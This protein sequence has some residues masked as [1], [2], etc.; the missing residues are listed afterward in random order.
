MPPSILPLPKE[1]QQVADSGSRCDNIGL[2]LD[3]FL[4]V[5]P[6]KNWGITQD[7]KHRQH[8]MQLTRQP[9]WQSRVREQLNALQNRYEAMLNWYERRGS[10]VK[11]IQAQPVW[12]FV[13]GLG[14]AHVLETGITLHRLF[15]L[16]IIPGSA[17]KGAARTWALFKL[18]EELGVPILSPSEA[19]A[20]PP[21][22]LDKFETVI[23][24]QGN[25]E[26]QA[27]LL[28]Q[29]LQDDAIPDGA[30]IR[31]LSLQELR[32][33]W[34]PFFEVFGSTEQAGSIIFLDA[35][36]LEPPEFQLDIMNPHY[37]NYYRTQGPPA[38]WESPN[39]VFFLTVSGTPYRFAIAARSEQ[40]NHLLNLAEKWLK[41]A[42]AELG[43]GA[44]TGADY[45]YWRV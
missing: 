22:T 31:K 1:V 27:A 15:G 37:P 38:D 9:A 45:G 42:L 30:P 4:T 2:W 25:E 44:K 40:G 35:I 17:L 19:S 29:L 14:A 8:L 43:V 12:R 10:V 33:K 3:R 24:S 28:S 21:T 32:E 26:E 18:S 16:P 13:V 6:Q 34:R 11:R 5:N 41:G 20:R 36:P 7:A 23:L 39:P